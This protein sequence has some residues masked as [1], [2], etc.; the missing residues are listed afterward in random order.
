VGAVGVVVLSEVLQ[1]LF[2]K[3]K[4]TSI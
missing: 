4:P 3:N 1:T 2:K